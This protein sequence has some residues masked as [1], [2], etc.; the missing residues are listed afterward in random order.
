ML[1]GS[2]KISST[3]P[4]K[5]HPLDFMHKKRLVHL[6]IKPN[7]IMFAS[8]EVGNL[9]IKLIDL[10]LSRELG[11]SN[12]VCTKFIRFVR[13]VIGDMKKMLIRFFFY[14]FVQI[15]YLV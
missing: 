3:I 2:P 12:K 9:Q 6:D 10:G 4:L 13:F 11:G 7:N 15:Q 5:G 14:I 8:S 1:G